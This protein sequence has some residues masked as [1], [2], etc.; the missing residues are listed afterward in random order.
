MI[1]RETNCKGIFRQMKQKPQ[2]I[3]CVIP[4]IYLIYGKNK[5]RRFDRDEALEVP[6]KHSFELC[7]SRLRQR[8]PPQPA[9]DPSAA[10][11]QSSEAMALLLIA[12]PPF[13]K[14]LWDT[15]YPSGMVPA[16][17]VYP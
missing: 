7:Q 17:I 16:G 5:A 11:K 9:D 2:Q 4:K 15:K 13:C 1:R 14:T 3:L 6:L 10:A 8:E 12:Y